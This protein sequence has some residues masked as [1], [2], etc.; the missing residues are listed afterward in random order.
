[1]SVHDEHLSNIGYIKGS[2]F[3][4]TGNTLLQTGAGV[5]Y[6]VI[7]NSHTSGVIRFY[8]GIA[9]TSGAPIGGSYTPAAGSSVVTFPQ[10]LEM[11]VGVWVQ[12]SG[13]LDMTAILS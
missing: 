5:L 3:P 8:D 1:M 13:T 11:K 12:T 4:F 9:G 2:Y 10:P 6:G 7:I